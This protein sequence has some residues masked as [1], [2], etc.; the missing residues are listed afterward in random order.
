LKAFRTRYDIS[1][2]FVMNLSRDASQSWNDLSSSANR[3]RQS[4]SVLISC[5]TI[6]LYNGRFHTVSDKPEP[7]IQES[8]LKAR[9][10]TGDMSKLARLQ[11]QISFWFPLNLAAES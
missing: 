10:V 1:E 7:S 6:A 3:L 2:S 9:S 8:H 5:F 11:I 4:L